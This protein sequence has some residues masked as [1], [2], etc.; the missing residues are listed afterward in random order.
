MKLRAIFAALFLI[1]QLKSQTVDLFYGW[2]GSMNLGPSIP[3]EELW[4]TGI[5][6]SS[7]VYLN[8]LQVINFKNQKKKSNAGFLMLPGLVQLGYGTVLKDQKDDSRYIDILVGSTSVALGVARMIYKPGKNDE[9]V[10]LLPF[11]L[12]SKSGFIAGFSFKTDL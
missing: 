5:L 1:T 8:T 6:T 3:H 12:P 2:N 10:S 11:Y 4:I 9:Q 7:N